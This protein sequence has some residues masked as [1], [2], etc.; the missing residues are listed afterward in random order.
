MKSLIIYFSRADENYSVDYVKKGNTE[1]IADYVKDFTGADLFNFDY[2]FNIVI[3]TV[4]GLQMHNADFYLIQKLLNM[5][6]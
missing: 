1:Y 4:F 3:V 2:T 5:H 6:Q